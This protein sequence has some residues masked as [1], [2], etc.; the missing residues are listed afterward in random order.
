MTKR[1]ATS[2]PEEEPKTKRPPFPKRKVAIL[3][4]YCGTNYQGMQL[5]PNAKTIELE[6]F[7]ALCKDGLVSSENAVDPKKVILTEW[8]T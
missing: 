4:G 8:S 3:M 1:E 6:L 5:N 7:N 2:E